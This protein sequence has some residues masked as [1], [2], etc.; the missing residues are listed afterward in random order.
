MVEK[1]QFGVGN[2]NY[3]SKTS[4]N[5]VKNYSNQDLRF[6]AVFDK[7][8]IRNKDNELQISKHAKERIAQ[9]GI[10]VDKDMINS[11]NNAADMARKKGAKDIVMI[12]KDAAFIVN[13][14]NSVIVTA[15]SSSE[16][17]DN[18]FTNIDSAVLI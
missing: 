2:V 5:P 17:K 6:R 1:T 7:Q 4:A 8:L 14:P 13:I 18:I 10:T 3:N 12:G 9:R 16:L 11:L 15:V